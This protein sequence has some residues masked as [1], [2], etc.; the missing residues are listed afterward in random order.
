MIFIIRFQHVSAQT[1]AGMEK[2]LIVLVR[3][4]ETPDQVEQRCT[5]KIREFCFDIGPGGVLLVRDTSTAVT[6]GWVK[7]EAVPVADSDARFRRFISL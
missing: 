1:K 5:V 6:V 4:A 7:S 3:T 2:H